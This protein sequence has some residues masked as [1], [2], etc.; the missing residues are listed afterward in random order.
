MDPEI[1]WLLQLAGAVI[2]LVL[3][4]DTGRSRGWI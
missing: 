2:G 1:R 3:L 4:I